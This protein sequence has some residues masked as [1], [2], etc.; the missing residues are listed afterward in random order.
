V[1]QLYPRALG[2]LY[3][4]SCDLKGY[5]G[6]IVTLR[7]NLEGQVPVYISLSNRMVQYK[8]KVTLRPVGH[9]EFLGVL[10]KRL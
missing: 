10:S 4:A 1:A 7:A 2:S 3:V 8:V 6:G 5:G 9:S